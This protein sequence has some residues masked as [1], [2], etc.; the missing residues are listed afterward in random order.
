[1]RKNLGD[2]GKYITKEQK[3]QLFNIYQKL[4]ENEVCKIYPNSFFGYTKI[5]VERP[6]IENGELKKDC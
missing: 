2:K 4:E 3:D 6:L 5:L 1:M